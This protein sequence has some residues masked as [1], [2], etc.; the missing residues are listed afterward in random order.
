MKLTPVNIDR[1]ASA[2]FEWDRRNGHHKG[3]PWTWHMI[4]SEAQ[5]N[6]RGLVRAVLAELDALDEAAIKEQR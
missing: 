2:A 5:E 3:G 1:L 4:G 6:Y